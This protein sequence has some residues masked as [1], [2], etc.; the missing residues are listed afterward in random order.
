MFPNSQHLPTLFSQNPRHGPVALDVA[1]NLAFPIFVVC[2]RQATARWM[3]VPKT[4]VNKNSDLRLRKHKIGFAAKRVAPSP[5][6]DTV[7]SQYGD[8]LLLG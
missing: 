3:P 6:R 8:K 4:T 7:F 1:L 2:G 5:S